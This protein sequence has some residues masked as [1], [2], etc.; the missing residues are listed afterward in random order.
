MA[1]RLSG[2][3]FVISVMLAAV[4]SACGPAPA[5]GD[6]DKVDIKVSQFEVTV[7]NTSGRALMEVRIEILPAG[8]STAYSVH[9]GRLEN[10]E[11]RSFSFDRFTD[12]DAVPFSPRTVR[13]TAVA[14]S[15]KDIDGAA[16][17]AE[18]PFKR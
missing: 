4:V 6:L 10:S 14:I 11:K 16:I 13:A 12:R 9:V 7:T 5:T 17:Q 15:A 2:R 3:L 8:R 18:V 1:P